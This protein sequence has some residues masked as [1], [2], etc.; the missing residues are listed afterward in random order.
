M[1]REDTATHIQTNEMLWAEVKHLPL[2]DEIAAQLSDSFYLLSEAT[3]HLRAHPAFLPADN[4]LS[5]Q[6]IGVCG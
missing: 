5:L 4:T 6:L 3:H 2:D 1:S